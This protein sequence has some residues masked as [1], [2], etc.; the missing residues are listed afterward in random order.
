MTIEHAI[1]IQKGCSNGFLCNYMMYN[2][3]KIKELAKQYKYNHNTYWI[4]L[5]FDLGNNISLA[6]YSENNIIYVGCLD[7]KDYKKTYWKKLEN[8]TTRITDEY[9]NN[10]FE[11]IIK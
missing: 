7:K 3:Y 8:I 9:L 10:I 2:D 6:I 1:Q 5:Y 11:Q 4:R